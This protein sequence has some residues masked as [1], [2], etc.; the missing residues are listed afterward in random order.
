MGDLQIES[1]THWSISVNNLDESDAFYGDLLGMDH[2]GRLGTEGMSCFGVGDHR[3][4]LCERDEP[5]DNIRERDPHV[6]YS[7]TV[8]TE[9][10]NKACK[11]FAER[12]V[13]VVELMYRRKG[14]FIG[15][16]LYFNDPSGNR[17]ELRDPTWKDGMPEPTYE[18][19]VNS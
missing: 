9:T 10:L 5:V 11:L 13:E 8:S 19:I 1:I 6:H 12:E 14:V 16:E 3:V 17:L 18:E 2:I 15:K 4:I 7:L